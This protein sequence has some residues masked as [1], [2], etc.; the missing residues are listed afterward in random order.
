MNDEKCIAYL[1]NIRD[2]FELGK[3]NCAGEALAYQQKFIDALNYSINRIQK[4]KSVGA[5]VN[6]IEVRAIGEWIETN[7]A[8]AERPDGTKIPHS[9]IERCSNCGHKISPL[10]TRVRNY[11]PNCGADMRGDKNGK[12]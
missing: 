6:T 12:S 5:V 8:Y 4:L 9:G 2:M 10:F 3:K 1:E 11:C 7:E